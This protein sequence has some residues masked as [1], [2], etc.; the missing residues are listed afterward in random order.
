[1]VQGLFTDVEVRTEHCDIKETGDMLMSSVIV[2]SV[3]T[4]R[5]WDSVYLSKHKIHYGGML[6]LVLVSWCPQVSINTS[7]SDRRLQA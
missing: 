4:D 1:M 6:L 7:N 5:L 2:L 3:R